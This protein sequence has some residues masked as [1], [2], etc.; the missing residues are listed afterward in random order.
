MQKPIPQLGWFV[1]YT[2]GRVATRE[3]TDGRGYTGARGNDIALDQVCA[4]IV[5]AHMPP[6]IPGGEILLNLKVQL[7]GE[8]IYWAQN[9]AEATGDEDVRDRWQWPAPLVQ[10]VD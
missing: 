6:V 4:A 1:H 5:V 9:V 8:D 3:I 7:D 10:P 2:L